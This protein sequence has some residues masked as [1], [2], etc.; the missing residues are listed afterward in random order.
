M[1]LAKFD[2]VI[3]KLAFALIEPSGKRSNLIR[4]QDQASEAEYRTLRKFS[5][6]SAYVWT[7]MPEF[8]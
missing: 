2:F 8:I 4:R 1:F 6:L 3:Q 7:Y 5:I